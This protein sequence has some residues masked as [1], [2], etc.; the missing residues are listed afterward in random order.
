MVHLEAVEKTYQASRGTVRA[1]AG[2]SLEI[3]A[4]QFAV[5]RGPSGSGKSTLLSLIGGLASPSGGHVRVAGED[6]ATMSAGA[7][8]AF[9]ARRIGFVFQTF[10][11]LPY[12]DVWQNVA[13]AAL[14]GERGSA[15]DRAREL[16]VRFRLQDRLQHRPA[17][18]STG[19][20]QR[21]AIAR[22]L[23]NKPSLLLADEPTGN[24]DAE[25]ATAILELIGAY[26]REGGT[27]ILVT[28]QEWIARHAQR[29][30][31]LRDGRVVP[32]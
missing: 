8:A 5:V 28:H 23:L 16:L 20:C 9:R 31:A 2:V 4:G 29:V 19:E 18:L 22:A 27:V 3:P 14:P 13:L 32:D 11:L 7:R 30:I 25:N 6:L 21:V 17:E 24:L 26:H 15:K 10:H 12:L 1:L